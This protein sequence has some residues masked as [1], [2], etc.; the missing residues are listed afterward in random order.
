MPGGYCAVS[1]REIAQFVGKTNACY[2]ISPISL[3]GLTDNDE[4]C[5]PPELFLGNHLEIQYNSDTESGRQGGSQL[6]D[7]PSAG[8]RGS[9]SEPITTNY[10]SALGCIQKGLGGSVQWSGEDR[11]T[12]DRQ[13][14]SSPHKLLGVAGS[15]PGTSSLWEGLEK[16]DNFTVYGQHHSSKLCQTE[17]RNE[18]RVT[19]PAGHINIELVQPTEDLPCSRTSTG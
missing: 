16:C 2:S 10:H 9:T 13:R 6:V 12:M 14:S 5:P 19:L 4:L 17:R 15:L 7:S 18:L 1:I 8:P 3:S 11:Q